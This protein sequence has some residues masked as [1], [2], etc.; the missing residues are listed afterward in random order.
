MKYK[1]QIHPVLLRFQSIK[2]DMIRIQETGGNPV[3]D[4]PSLHNGDMGQYSD[5][6]EVFTQHSDIFHQK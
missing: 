2:V 1:V 5:D 6:R 4:Q 3:G